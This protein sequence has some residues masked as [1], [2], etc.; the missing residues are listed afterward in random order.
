MKYFDLHCDT[1]YRAVKENLDFYDKKMAVDFNNPPFEIYAQVFAAFIEDTTQNGFEDFK[2]IAGRMA[3]CGLTPCVSPEG[4]RQPKCALLS[5]EN[6]TAL[7]EE[8][9]NVQ[10]LYDCGVRMMTLTWNGQNL[11]G[12]G[13]KAEGGLTC[14]GRDVIGEMNRLGMAVDLSHINPEG[15]DQA[16]KL[17]NI[18]VASH[19]CF[20]TVCKHTRNLTDKRACRIAEKGGLIGICVY[21]EFM[22]DNDPFERVAQQFEHGMRLSLENNM[23]FGTDFDGADMDERLSRTAQ[24]PELHGFLCERWQDEK[25]VDKFFYDNAQRFYKRVLTNK[26]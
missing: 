18:P 3:E 2:K 4:L 11:L 25:L 24:I 6:G 14:F 12:S 10:K 22:G 19:S 1:F 21:P 23:A 17:A 26:H 5:V 7:G 13:C 20:D 16:I 15:F 8:I 9:S